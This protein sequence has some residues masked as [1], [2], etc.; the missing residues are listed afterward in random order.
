[1]VFAYTLAKPAD[2]MIRIYDITGTLI[3]VKAIP[4]TSSGVTAWD[5]VNQFGQMSSN[6]IYPYFFSAAKDGLV[7][8]RKGKII[9]S[10]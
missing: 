4:N 5:G 2:L 3:W 7:E 6:G 8:T 9:I 1:M 10:Q